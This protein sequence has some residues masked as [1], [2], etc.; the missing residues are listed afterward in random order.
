[1]Q[2]LQAALESLQQDPQRGKH[3][4]G[5]LKQHRSIRV[6]PYRILYKLEKKRL[7]VYVI[8]ISHRQGGI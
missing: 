3:L 7:I 2:R 5:R 6:W 8:R 4:G 1:M